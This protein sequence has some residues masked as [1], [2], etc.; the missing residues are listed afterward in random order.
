[1]RIRKFLLLLVF[2]PVLK[3]A[4]QYSVSS[5]PDSLTENAHAVIREYTVELALQS[6]NKGSKKIRKVITVLDKNGENL[7]VLL[8]QYDRDSHINIKQVILYNKDGKKIK[9][10]KQSEI[11][12]APAF[13]SYELFSD[14]RIKAY[15]PDL[16]EY[17]FTVEYDY[18]IDMTNMISYGK[19]SPLQNYNMSLQHA[20]LTLTY[21]EDIKIHRKEHLI[22]EL[23]DGPFYKKKLATWEI[24]NMTAVEEEPYEVGL[25]ERLPSVYLM[26]EHLIYNKHE[27]NA[28]NWKDYGKWIYDL[29]KDRDNIPEEE[30]AKIISMVENIPDTLDKIKTLYQYMQN[31]TR[32]VAV[33]MGIGGFQPFDASTV[34]RTGYGDCKALSNYMYTMLKMIGIRSYPA[35]VPAGTVKTSV[36][37]DFPNFHQFNHAILCVPRGKDTIWLECTNQRIPFGF[38]GDFADDRDVLLITENGGVFAHT[39]KYDGDKNL[40]SGMTEIRINPTGSSQIIS[41]IR[42]SGLWYDNIEEILSMN[43]D[44][45]KKWLYSNTSLPSLQINDFSF[46]TDKDLI[47][48]AELKESLESKNYCSFAGKYMILPVNRVNAQ[49]PVQKM[50]RKRLSD[51][52]I[53]RSFTDS[54]TI[55]FL[56]PENYSVESL[57]DSISINSDFGHYSLSISGNKNEIACVRNFVLNEGRYKPENYKKFYDF[58]E[59]VSKADNTKIMLTKK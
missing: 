42:F 43:H 44:Q 33:T 10:I 8:E 53:N 25:S 9:A 11:I 27:G 15:K 59:A 31:N 22:H 54:D 35:L 50:L 26:P 36:F 4:G 57:P 18:E 38:L 47:P 56:I 20:V 23:S 16:A 55:L 41:T 17:P 13:S 29:F 19:W 12:D 34:Y 48:S 39:C 1:M 46:Y 49:D 37:H 21:P 51:I 40:R 2:L 58:I 45:Q 3:A 32:Y 14:D 24:K 30:R 28:G 7:A 52:L 5:I 6:V